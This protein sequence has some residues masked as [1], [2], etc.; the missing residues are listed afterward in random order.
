MPFL[1]YQT[2]TQDNAGQGGT[3]LYGDVVYPD[4]RLLTGGGYVWAG[5]GALTITIQNTA[6]TGGPKLVALYVDEADYARGGTISSTNLIPSPYLAAG[7]TGT[8]TVT[9]TKPW[10]RVR[11]TS[12]TKVPAAFG[13]AILNITSAVVPQW[14]CS[15]LDIEARIGI[16]GYSDYTVWTSILNGMAPDMDRRARGRGSLFNTTYTDELFDCGK[17]ALTT[18]PLQGYY[19]RSVDHVTENDNLLLECKCVSYLS[20][21]PVLSGLVWIDGYLLQ[22]GD[23]VLVAGQTNPAE[24]GPYRATNGT[25]TRHTA[26]ANVQANA[27]FYVW[28]GTQYNRTR[29]QLNNDNPIAVGID[30]IYIVQ[31]DTGMRYPPPFWKLT[32]PCF[33]QRFD[34]NNF[35]TP[36]RRFVRVTYTAGYDSAADTAPT[37]PM[38]D[39]LRNAALKLAAKTFS[40][41]LSV[42]A[43]QVSGGG[44]NVTISGEGPYWREIESVLIRYQEG[45]RFG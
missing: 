28:N 29:W 40:N 2:R 42:G 13:R 26:F 24:N 33:L 15:L 19:I 7:A 1:V 4:C 31:T 6:A 38:P 17:R 21:L 41:R 20:N 12:E 44:Q 9:T 3:P 34:Q 11:V 35:T 36:W 43:T 27:Q 23:V 32:Q 5:V 45:W 8:Y 25:W 16:N 14:F 18:I 37:V 30:P 10:V 22:E 39:D